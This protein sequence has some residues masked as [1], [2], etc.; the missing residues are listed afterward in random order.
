MGCDGSNFI[1]LGVV[2]V[3]VEVPPAPRVDSFLGVDSLGRPGVDGVLGWI[4][5]LL[6]LLLDVV[7]GVRFTFIV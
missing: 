6:V 3:V 2:V 5:T 4:F 7:V 1:V